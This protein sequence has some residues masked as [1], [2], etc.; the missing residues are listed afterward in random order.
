[1]NLSEDVFEVAR[2]FTNQP[3]FV[4][5]NYG[6]LYEIS[7]EIKKDYLKDSNPIKKTDIKFKDILIEIVAN[8]INYCFWYGT[9]EVRP[10]QSSSTNLYKIIYE[11]FEDYPFCSFSECINILCTLLSIQRYPLIEERTKHLRQLVRNSKAENLAKMIE[12]KNMFGFD[13]ITE[14]VKRFPGYASDQFLKRASLVVL[15]LYR[16]YGM[17]SEDLK[18]IHIPSDYQVPKVMNALGIIEYNQELQTKISSYT[19]LPKSSLEECEIRSSTILVAKKLVY[20][21]DLN[22]SDID[23]WFFEKRYKITSP[24]HLTVTTDY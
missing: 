13:V 16:Q 11:C 23:D 12:D 4:K 18:V 7:D 1:M 22:V 9:S 8:S 17:F 19:H 24:F 5:I 15:Q 3:K 20:E 10:N 6:R 2:Q 21:T 14:L